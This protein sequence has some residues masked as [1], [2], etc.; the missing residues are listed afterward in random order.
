M[1]LYE[2]SKFRNSFPILK[3]QLI[4]VREDLRYEEMFDSDSW[5]RKKETFRDKII[6]V[7]DVLRWNHHTEETPYEMEDAIKESYPSVF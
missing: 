1:S 2:T 3:H 6:L 7:I 4:E 5:N